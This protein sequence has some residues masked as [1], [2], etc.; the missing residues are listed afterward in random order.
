MKKVLNTLLAIILLMPSVL[1]AQ[2]TTTNSIYI[3]QVGEGSNITITQKGQ[4]NSIG[5]EAN[6][7]QIQGDTQTITVKQEGNI[8]KIDGKIVQADSIDYDV[9]F[10]GDN[11][12]LAV[13]HGDGA[14]VAGSKLVVSVAG[15]SNNLTLTQ[16]STSS[17]T[18]ADQEIS[19]TGDGNNY[20]STINA[21]DVKNRMTIAGDNNTKTVVQNGFAGKEVTST[22]TGNGNTITVNQTSTLNVDKL[23]ITHTGNNNTVAISQCNAGS[24]C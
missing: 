5:T 16:G 3:D 24:T 10:T 14:S 15:D 22:V 2:Q 23:N 20:T 18:N 11:N 9:T 17:S 13:D 8:N 19:V 21:D 6:R 12:N 7:V 4:T 1:V